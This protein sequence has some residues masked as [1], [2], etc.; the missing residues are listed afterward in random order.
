MLYR[1][2]NMRGT[3]MKFD[4]NPSFQL[5]P[6]VVTALQAIAG[7]PLAPC[8]V[9][10]TYLRTLV[11]LP[12]DGLIG[13]IQAEW[14]RGLTGTGLNLVQVVPKPVANQLAAIYNHLQLI[15]AVRAY[16]PELRCRTDS[17]EMTVLLYVWPRSHPD[18]GR[19]LGSG[20]LSDTLLVSNVSLARLQQG[21][22]AVLTML[23]EWRRNTR[24]R[25][26]TLSVSSFF[27][28]VRPMSN[29]PVPPH[30]AKINFGLDRIIALPNPLSI[31]DNL[32]SFREVFL[33]TEVGYINGS[34]AADRL[35]TATNPIVLDWSLSSKDF[36][37]W[38]DYARL[39]LDLLLRLIPPSDLDT[40]LNEWPSL[41]VSLRKLTLDPSTANGRL[42]PSGLATVKS[43]RDSFM[44]Q[45]QENAPS[46]FWL[47]AVR[48]G[49]DVVADPLQNGANRLAATLYAAVALDVAREDLKFELPEAL[50]VSVS[51]P[52]FLSWRSLPVHNVA[53]GQALLVG[54]GLFTNDGRIDQLPQV[55]Y[56]LAE[57]ASF[58]DQRGYTVHLLLNQ[59]F[60]GSNLEQKL[61]TLKKAVGHTDGPLLVCFCGHGVLRN[62]HYYLLTGDATT[63]TIEEKAIN[64]NVWLKQITGL[65]IS[66]TVILVN[67]CYS[68]QVLSIPP[69]I[70][71]IED[72]SY[73][74]LTSASIGEQSY[75]L[76]DDPYSLFIGTVLEALG[77][78]NAKGKPIRL[79]ELLEYV[80]HQVPWRASK[81]GMS[82]HPTYVLKQVT[83]NFVLV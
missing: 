6:K 11:Q 55:N 40:W 3:Q 25:S 53:D 8:P 29:P 81:I 4:I 37:V 67:S 9:T 18:A 64:L 20:A 2:S 71:S 16:I 34:L 45:G 12:D 21:L 52:G 72:G 51:W 54:A 75:M 1:A 61:T 48:A 74:V 63:G 5:V 62:G 15:D 83:E 82:Q 13:V 57:M 49:L 10:A 36:P 24:A 80:A 59:E 28:Q 30:A 76:R 26:S 7:S 70:S 41:A 44:Q 73:V 22:G 33:N 69:D 17:E 27:E 66:R 47:S 43:I 77:R 56:D 58:L 46:A 14:E 60:T 32:A 65:G 79:F 42:V 50:P 38:L 78:G 39:E 68:G 31:L 35:L 19:A 23:G